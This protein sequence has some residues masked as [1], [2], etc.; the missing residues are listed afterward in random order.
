ME[1]MGIRQSAMDRLIKN[2]KRLSKSV[3]SRL[4]LENDDKASMYSV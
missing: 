1:F 3:Q 4:T 2:F